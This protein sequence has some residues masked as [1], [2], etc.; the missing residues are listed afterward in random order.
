M[1]TTRLGW[2]IAILTLLLDQVSKHWLVDI[3]DI[4]AKG[5]IRVTSWFDIV[6][7]WNRGIS[8]GLFQ[9]EHWLARVGFVALAIGASV[10]CAV[11]MKRTTSRLV[12]AGL[13]LLIGGALGNAIDR[14]IH[15]AVIDFVSLHYGGFNWYIFNIADAAIVAAVAA[16]LYDSLGSRR[17]PAGKSG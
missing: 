12:A 11:W 14:A 17:N 3:Y 4:A 5:P 16:L 10:F 8:Y 7:V 15:G 6:L 2:S 13:G 9:Q 1:S